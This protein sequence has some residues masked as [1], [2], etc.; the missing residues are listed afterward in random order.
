MAAKFPPRPVPT[1]GRWVSVDPAGGAK[2]TLAVVWQGGDPAAIVKAHRETRVADLAPVFAGAEVVVIESGHGRSNMQTAMLLAHARGVIEGAAQCAGALVVYVTPEQWRGVHGLPKRAPRGQTTAVLHR[3]EKALCEQL[4]PV[5]PMFASATNEDT[6]AALLI[7]EACAVRWG[8]TRPTVAFLA[9]PPRKRE[10][11]PTV[12]RKPK[13]VKLPKAG[14]AVQLATT[15]RWHRVAGVWGRAYFIG[16][17]GTMRQDEHWQD[18][19]PKGGE[20]CPRCWQ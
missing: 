13:P 15:D 1:V 16:C 11:L 20:M 8:W 2:P 5:R 10:R 19:P 7:G 18:A 9:A 6:R 4:A 3:A 14:Q 12:P 17:D